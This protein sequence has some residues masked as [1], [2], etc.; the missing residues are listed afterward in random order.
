[1][2]H[3]RRSPA[4]NLLSD[5]VSS[6]HPLDEHPLCSTVRN[7]EDESMG[8]ARGPA[9]PG[10]HTGL[11]PRPTSKTCFLTVMAFLPAASPALWAALGISTRLCQERCLCSQLWEHDVSWPQRPPRRPRSNRPGRVQAPARVR[12]WRPEPE[13]PL[14]QRLVLGGPGTGA[15]S[16]C[17]V[18]PRGTLA[19]TPPPH[20]H[21][22]G[23]V[24]A[25]HLPWPLR[26]C[27]ER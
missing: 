25:P 3:A 5:T 2:Q 23:R 24:A 1:M 9:G 17:R 19:N 27:L 6:L 14:G 15:D 21:P 4:V 20:Q 8:Q 22:P 10:S 16:L 11:N 18:Q 12:G 26:R 7:N 13:D